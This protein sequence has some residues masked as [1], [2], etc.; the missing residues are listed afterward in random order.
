[1]VH[2]NRIMLGNQDK[3]DRRQHT[4]VEAGGRLTSHVLRYVNIQG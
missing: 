3:L 1:M 2:Y 4:N